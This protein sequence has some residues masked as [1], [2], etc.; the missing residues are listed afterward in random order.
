[1][2]GTA[3]DTSEITLVRVNGIDATSTDNFATWQIQV[4][5]APGVNTLRV[6][7]GDIAQNG[8]MMAASVQIN[9]YGLGIPFPNGVALDSANNRALVI[10]KALD[11]LVAVDLTS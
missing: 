2:R 10:D 8:N 5:L 1:M 3:T 7:T 6:E 9:A 11:A 4:A